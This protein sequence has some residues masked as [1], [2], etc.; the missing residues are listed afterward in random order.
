LYYYIYGSEEYKNAAKYAEKS[1][2]LLNVSM[3]VPLKELKSLNLSANAIAG[4]LP[5]EGMFSPAPSAFHFS[6]RIPLQKK[7]KKKKKKS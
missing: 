5:N 4:C 3:L 7:K 2:W 1:N 6:Y